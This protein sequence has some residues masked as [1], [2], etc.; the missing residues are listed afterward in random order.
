MQDFHV[1]TI[2][3]LNR[4]LKAKQLRLAKA[5]HTPEFDDLEFEFELLRQRLCLEITYAIESER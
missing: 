5:A 4:L 2:K 1:A 3:F